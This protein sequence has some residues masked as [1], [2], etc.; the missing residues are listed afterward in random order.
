MDRPLPNSYWVI[1][2]RLLAGEY[3]FGADDADALARLARLDQAGVD[4]FVDLT[5]EYEQPGYRHLLPARSTYVRSAITDTWV[6]N[7]AAQMRK[8]LSD[9]REA[10]SLGRCVYVHCR[11]GIGRTGLVIGCFLAEE[12]RSG[13]SALRRLN[14]L[15]QQSA[16][17]G[18]WP[19]VP[20]TSEQADYI[21]LWPKLRSQGVSE[22]RMTQNPT[23]HDA[24]LPAPPG[25]LIVTPL[26]PDL[27]APLLLSVIVPTFNEALN[28]DRLVTELAQLLDG[29]FGRRYEIIV[30]DDDS[31][32]RTWELALKLMDERPSLR[33]MRREAE[34]GLSSAVIRG[35][36]V[37]RGEVLCVIDADLQHPPKVALALYRVIER[38]AQMAVASRHLEGGGVSDWSVTRRI[39]SRTAQIMGLLILPGVVGRV[40][41]PLSGYF[42]I[43]RSAIEGAELNPLGYKILIEVMARGRFPWVGEVPYVFSERAHGGSKASARVYIDYLRHLLRLRFSS[44]PVNRFIRF[45]TVGLSGV[46]V[47]MGLLY[48]LSDPTMLAWGLTRS[49]LIAAEMAILNNFFWNDRW[50]FRD[51]SAKQRGP[52]ARLRRFGKFQLVCLAG[53]AINATLLNLQFNLLGMNRYVAN[54]VAIAAVTAWN[55]GLNLKLSW[56]MVEPPP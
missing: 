21:R 44:L 30:V 18:S 55:F 7:D 24:L 6:P 49:K 37:A 38:G 36:Q 47:D 27:G 25:P 17:A 12:E 31:P 16:R 51:L 54:A 5:H 56:R 4:Y 22:A 41:D 52:K 29:P 48:L 10:L 28:I 43:R 13:K 39:V 46:I 15:W 3:P 45:A 42:M 33:V 23:A 9:I 2:G 19:K 53:V 35:W 40:S 26:D 1:P 32:D 14:R 50:T 20:Q 8:I 11:A 34:R